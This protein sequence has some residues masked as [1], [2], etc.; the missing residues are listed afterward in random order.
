MGKILAC[1]LDGTLFYPMGRKQLVSQKNIEFL[2][3]FIDA[4]NKVVFISSRG[5]LKIEQAIKEVDRP[6]DYISFN[7]CIISIDGEIVR[8]LSI[9]TNMLD[10]IVT[11]IVKD[12][13]PL[14][15]LSSTAN[16]SIIIGIYGAAGG[17]L[18][19]FYRK[20]YD[21]KYGIYAEKYI[22]SNDV[23]DDELL[24][25]KVYTI[26][27]F[28]GLSRKKAK[29]LNKELNKVLREQFPELEASWVGPLI[30]LTP[31]GCSKAKSLNDY[32]EMVKANKDEVYVI[33][34]SGNDISMFNEFKENSFVMKHSYPSVKKY[35]KHEVSRVYKLD[36]YLFSKEEK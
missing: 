5:R 27:V 24:N 29:N 34:D 16:Y 8:D 25:G 4:G 14:A 30:E 26:R 36:K 6:I 7:G 1:D 10:Y 22:V 19:W 21:L 9:P 31:Y 20:Y 3:K 23:F 17:F 15:L 18:K 13:N 11:N 33:G 12:H 35:A 32:L 2:R 28:S